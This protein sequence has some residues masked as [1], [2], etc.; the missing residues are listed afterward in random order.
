M[1]VCNKEKEDEVLKKI[2]NAVAKDLWIVLLDIIAVN[3]AYYLA[4]I[5]R[6]FVGGELRAVAV[7]RYM[8]AWISFTPWYSVLAIIIFMAWKLYG[9]MWRYAGINDMNRIILANLCT[10]VLHVAGTTLFFT[11]MPWTYYAIGGVLQ[12]FLVTLI[13]FAYRLFLVE[14]TKLKRVEKVPALVVGSGDLGRKVIRHLEENTPYRAVAILSS[15]SSGRSLD[16]IPVLPLDS[17]KEEIER[18]GVRAVFIADKELS[19]GDREKVK[20]AAGDREITDFTGALSNNSGYLPVS[21][22]LSLSAGP[23]VLVVDG[24]EKRFE[25]G[26]EAL[27]SLKDRY[28]VKSISGATIELEKSEDWTAGFAA[29]YK[30][31]TGEDVSFF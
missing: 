6:F 11:R 4:L 19:E 1:R 13:R 2:W 18:R 14:K 10:T 5:T 21:T 30:A 23:V 12:F 15:S 28:A 17:I 26:R 8:P 24:K 22:L 29:D 27:E 9:G 20:A 16:G 7:E 31:V 3:A 25:S